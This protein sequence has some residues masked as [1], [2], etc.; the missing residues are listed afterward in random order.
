M[1]ITWQP[2]SFWVWLAWLVLA[3]PTALFVFALFSPRAAVLGR[4][5]PVRLAV[6]TLNLL[7]VACLGFSLLRPHQITAQTHQREHLTL[8][9][10]SSHSMLRTPGGWP[11]LRADLQR[12]CRDLL[13]A[14]PQPQRQRAVVSLVSFGAVTRRHFEDVPLETLPTRLRGLRAQDLAPPRSSQLGEALNQALGLGADSSARS[15]LLYSDGFT[16]DPQTLAAAR[17]AARDAVPIYIWEPPGAVPELA[18]RDLYLPPI[19]AEKVPTYLRANLRNQKPQAAPAVIA[20][21][22]W[23]GADH[24]RAVTQPTTVPGDGWGRLRVPLT[25]RRRGLHYVDFALQDADG[26]PRHQRRVFA[27]VTRPPK[28]LAIGGDNRWVNFFPPERGQVTAINAEQLNDGIRLDDYDAVILNDVVADQFSTEALTRI[29]AAVRL[30]GLGLFFANGGHEG[31]ADT[32]ATTLMSYDETPLEP[33]L[34][35]TTEP[36]PKS[37]DYLSRHVIMM[38]DASGSMGGRRM[39]TAQALMQYIVLDLL[40]G[41]DRLDLIAFTSQAEHLVQNR[42]LDADGKAFALAQIR[43]IEASGGTDPT[44]ALKLLEDRRFRNCGLIFISDGYFMPVDYRPDCRPTVFAIDQIATKVS[45]ALRKIADPIA[46]PLGTSPG[47]LEIPFFDEQERPYFYEPTAFDPLRL[48]F[49]LDQSER[50]PM[51]RR[52]LPGNAVAKIKPQARLIAIRPKFTDPVLAY[53]DAELGS[54]GAFTSALPLPIGRRDATPI[55]VEW[56]EHVLPFAAFNRYQ[57][58]AHDQG[59]HLQIELNL[60]SNRGRVPRIST[61]DLQWRSRLGQIETITVRKG[62]RAGSFQG[63]LTLPAEGGDGWLEIREQGADALPRSQRLALRLP[64][65]NAVTNAG[66]S[67]A[68][69]VGINH[70]L[71]D[72]LARLS[73]G[74]RLAKGATPFAGGRPQAAHG[75]D[76]RPVLWLLAALLYAA[77]VALR[78]WNPHANPSL[79]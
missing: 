46:V 21:R 13:A 15:I 73:G 49:I 12:H 63:R 27:Q 7:A 57:I 10:D 41:N 40:G 2:P 58:S 30:R 19:V 60:L 53:G 5:Q 35:V 8:L 37:P 79:S 55:W 44:E 50:L 75:R 36:R 32:D 56:F 39:E 45:P 16:T 38:V 29:A 1:A 61:V 68:E 24:Q 66:G 25:F 14:L 23:F 3:L 62:T 33:L 59:A 34:P 67:E 64:P 42:H 4:A 43:S 51:P 70:P 47:Q 48:D 11:A 31:G 9:V 22:G 28:Y 17:R 54:V 74:D 65:V 6:L 72:Q 18:I 52:P 20:V 77:A 78:R 71:L 26:R 76:L 69:H